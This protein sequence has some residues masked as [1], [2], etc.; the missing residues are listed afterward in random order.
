MDQATKEKLAKAPLLVE[1]GLLAK[2][3]V[4]EEHADLIVAAIPDNQHI[5]AVK[6]SRLLGADMKGQ[7][8][9]IRA[10]AKSKAVTGF[11]LAAARN[12]SINWDEAAQAQCLTD[13]ELT[14]IVLAALGV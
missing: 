7:A 4:L 1:L 12:V 5:H 2:A 14:K 13:D 6:L 9:I 11:N 8:S 10:S 3:E